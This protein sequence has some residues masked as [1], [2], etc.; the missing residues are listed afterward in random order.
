MEIKGKIGKYKILKKLGSG[1][2]GTVYLA[3]DTF[4]KS[5]RALKIPHGLN[6]QKEKIL[7]E[8]IVQTKLLDHPNI[9][10]LLTVDIID[11]NIVMVMEYVNGTDLEKIID[12]SVKLSIKRA[13]AYF[14]QI[15]SALGYA[16]ENKILH[17]DIRPSNILISKKN[18]V[19]ITDFG[20]STFL[21]ESQHATTKIGSPPYMAPE[22]F[23]GKA[24][25]A[26]DIYS[27]GCLFYEMITGFPPIVLANPM[28][29]YKRAKA[30]DFPSL[31]K[32]IPTLA[33]GINDIIMKTLSPD[34]SGRYKTT[35]D[36]LAAF[37][38]LEEKKGG[39]PSEIFDIKKRIAARDERTDHI[40]WSCR[41]TIPQKVEKCIYCGADQ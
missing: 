10:K 30:G 34:I 38:S 3:E 31:I 5:Q 9:V 33:P 19:K 11:D 35:G 16:H 17:R 27:A 21:E 13:I 20:T 41:K 8:S 6:S 39:D 7:K 24:V 15:L 28:E 12:D 40:C 4:L 26:S 25:F 14:R 1:G 23:E 18:E 36:I 2:F 32:K 29:I 22:Q 37:D